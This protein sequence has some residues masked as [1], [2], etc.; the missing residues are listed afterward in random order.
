MSHLR[1]LALVATAA[2]AGNLYG[3]GTDPSNFAVA[4]FY[5]IDEPNALTAAMFSFSVPT[6][7]FVSRLAYY[8]GTGHFYATASNTAANFNS[9][10]MDI[11]PVAQTTTFV[12]VA[13]NLN[14]EGLDYYASLSS[15]VVSYSPTTFFTNTVA[16]IT[17]GGVPGTG[18]NNLG[19]DPI[20]GEMLTYDA[21]NPT[22][23]FYLNRVLNPFGSPTVTGLYSGAVD[24]INDW[25]IASFGG[26]LYLTHSTDLVKFAPG[27]GSRSTVGK[28]GVGR[29]SIRGIA[30]GPVPEPASLLVLGL[31]AALLRRRRR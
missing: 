1:T 17:T 12:P 18:A 14:L 11:D 23:S 4:T 22:G 16:T 7:Y 24:S 30:A 10:L 15:L 19:V 3:I 25:D 13:G 20:T 21:S 29:D 26:D 6:N 8:P 9:G 28:F 31:G 27:F 2:S 5:N